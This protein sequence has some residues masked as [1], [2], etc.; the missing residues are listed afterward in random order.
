MERSQRDGDPSRRRSAAA[1][2]RARRR[3]N[4]NGAPRTGLMKR[5]GQGFKP[6]R[7]PGYQAADGQNGPNS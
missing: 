5:E 4:L 1:A 6:G 7:I 3:P 2:T